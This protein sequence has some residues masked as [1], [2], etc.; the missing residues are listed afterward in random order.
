MET[1][2]LAKFG[3]GSMKEVNLT[4]L[5]AV[6]VTVGPKG[7]GVDP[8]QQVLIDW[9]KNIITL[10]TKNLLTGR[11]D[12][13]D[14]NAKGTLSASLVVDPI[15]LTAE[16]IAVNL[17]ANP[18][19][20]FVDRGVKG[21]VSSTRSPNSPFSFKKKGGGKSDNVGPMTQAIA[22]WITDKGI[23]VTPTY[24]REKKAMRTVQ[25][26]KLEDA[27][28][29]TYFVRRRGLYATNFLSNALTNEQIDVLINTISEVLGKQVSLSTEK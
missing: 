29:I 16:K 2:V 8:R 7:K 19:W 26:Q 12:G 21:T 13:K 4:D 11:E 15:P 18:Y 23:L 1:K 22:D 5:Q 27:R 6:G 24:S 14:V 10:A 3:S 9:V 25:E 20:K 28:S 17:L